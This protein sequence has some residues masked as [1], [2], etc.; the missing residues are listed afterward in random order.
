[1]IN[2]IVYSPLWET[3]KRKGITTYYLI[4]KCG[5]SSSTINNIKHNKGLSTATINDLCNILDCDVGDIMKHI[6]DNKPYRTV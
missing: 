6:P 2:L 3:M 1:M 4:N 5:I